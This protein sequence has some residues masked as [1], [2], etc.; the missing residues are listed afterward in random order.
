MKRL[1]AAPN[2]KEDSIFRFIYDSKV[3]AKKY[4]NFKVKKES[5]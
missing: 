3:L 4:N 5:S 2:F 1:I